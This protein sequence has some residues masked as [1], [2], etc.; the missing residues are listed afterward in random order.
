[1]KIWDVESGKASQT[2]LL[3]E[4]GVVSI[5]DHQV[6]VVW[7]PRS[8]NLIISLSLSGDF[9]YLGLDESN[10]R[11]LVHGHQKN[12]TTLAALNSSPT[13]WT[14]DSSGRVCAWDS[15]KGTSSKIDGETHQNYVSGLVVTSRSISSISWDDTLRT[16][17]PSALAFTGLKPS[18]DGQPRGVA[19]IESITVVGTHKALQII[20]SSGV[21]LSNLTTNFATLCLVAQDDT[22]VVGGDDTSLHIYSLSGEELKKFKTIQTEGTQPSALAFTDD[23]SMVAVGHADGKIT[24]YSTS[25]WSIAISRWS[26]H[27]GKVQSI[28]WRKDGRFAVSGALDTNIYIWSVAKPGKRVVASNAHKEGV[29]GVTWRGDNTV[30]SAGMDATVKSWNVREL[31]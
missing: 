25:D 18:T 23:G 9:N 21:Q 20:D 10:P 4:K 22:V 12:I 28:A 24:V 11:R 26:A 3:G 30:I 16:I 8:D 6:G 1:M 15:S 13:L 14:G 17:D 7:T 29:N 5:P 31:E 27:T 2:W 19:S